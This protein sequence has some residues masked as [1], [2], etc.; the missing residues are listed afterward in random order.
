[1][2]RVYLEGIAGIVLVHGEGRYEDCA[3][4]SNGVHSRDHIVAGHLFRPLQMT[5]PGAFLAV[6]VIAV[7]LAING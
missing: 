6:A 2:L 3:V 5:M 4:D 1:M 7:D